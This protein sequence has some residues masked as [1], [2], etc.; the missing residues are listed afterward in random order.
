[1]K[2]NKPIYIDR[3]EIFSYDEDTGKIHKEKKNF[4]TKHESL[5]DNA[6]F[7]IQ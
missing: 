2:K 1:M 5:P 4:A 7:I 6:K 3:D